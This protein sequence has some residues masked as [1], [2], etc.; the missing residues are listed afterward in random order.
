MNKLGGAESY[1]VM[2]DF[3][4]DPE[5]PLVYSYEESQSTNAEGLD[6]L[7]PDTWTAFL[8]RMKA[9]FEYLS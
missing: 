5:T 2:V 3:F 9:E 1:R 7:T 8:N 4:T 6:T